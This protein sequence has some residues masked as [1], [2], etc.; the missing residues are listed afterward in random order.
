ML[1]AGHFFELEIDKPWEFN[2]TLPIRSVGVNYCIIGLSYK[3][4]KTCN[5]IAQYFGKTVFT[6]YSLIVFPRL[7]IC[8]LSFAVDY[9]LHKLCLNNNENYKSK[10]T[11]L[12]SSY[13]M[14][15]YATHTFSN[16][17]E[18]ILLAL[19]IYYVA[20][21]MIFSNIVVKQHEYLN[22]R[23]KTSKTPMERAK[24]HK[25]RL[26][27]SPHSF[28]NCF[29]ISSITVIGFF[30]RP[31]FLAFAVCPIFF[32]LYRGIGFKSVIIMHLHYRM[33]SLIVCAIPTIVLFVIIDSFYY[34]YLSLAEIEF[35]N[36]DINN[37][38]FIPLNFFKYNTNVNNLALHGLHPKY[39]HFLVNFPL[40]F[41]I[42]ALFSVIYLVQ[43]CVR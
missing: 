19:L 6:P 27:L 34:G 3:F 5:Y 7:F 15:V 1:I 20:E 16:A 43:M 23:Y 33:V 8:I 17:I 21:S 4:L 42:L 18:L 40:L 36:I 2:S 25:L 32:W 9:A 29:A 22:K 37:F 38:V 26:L 13:V 31:T 14:V 41:N 24:I 12:A 28:K 11:I 39:L 35:L 10:I 30:N